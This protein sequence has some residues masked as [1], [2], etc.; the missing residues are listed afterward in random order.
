MQTKLLMGSL[1]VA[2]SVLAAEPAPVAIHSRHV[3]DVKSGTSADEY[4]VVRGE[5]IASIAKTPPAGARV[6]DLGDATV[7]PGFIDCHVHL[8]FDWS[9]LSSTGFLRLSAAQRTL[10][11]IRNAQTYLRSGFTT[12][13]D[14][15]END[16]SYGQVALRDAFAN[17]WLDGPRLS[18]AGIPISTTGGHNDTDVLAPDFRLPLL[19]NIADT[20][21]QVRIAARHDLK[22]GVDWVKLMGTGG[23]T[24]PLSDFNTQEMSDEMFRAAVDV[25]HRAHRRVM[26]HAEG[27]D[28][29]KAAVRAGV[30]TIEHGTVLDEEGAKLLAEHGTWLVPTLY[31]FQHGVEIGLSQ[32]QEPIMLEKGKAILKSQQPSM[33]LARKYHVKIAFGLDDDPKGAAHEFE[34]L[35]RAGLTPLQALQAGTINAAEL[36]Q[37]S[38]DVGSL[39]PEHYADVIAIDGDPLRD[40]KA[41]SKVVFVMKGGKVIL[42]P[43]AK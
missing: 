20:A 25:A 14:A 21:D 39:E 35:V 3:L 2:A 37:M 5:R 42:P 7:L 12:L 4:I 24:D 1:L 26:V 17:G 13:R 16:P 27:T 31:T 43:V 8:L 11:G 23:V 19:P 33:D 28:G 9:D 41:T 18:V 40:I 34:A 38:N 30:D 10:W 32:G 6:I 36:L 22:Y 29:I 15:G